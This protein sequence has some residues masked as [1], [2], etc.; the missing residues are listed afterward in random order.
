MLVVAMAHKRLLGQ[1]LILGRDLLL[2]SINLSINDHLG[3]LSLY[4]ML[5]QLLQL[6]VNLII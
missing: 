2:F 5:I 1:L 6:S 4:L 3:A